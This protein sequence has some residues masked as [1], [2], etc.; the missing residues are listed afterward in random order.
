M[1]NCFHVLSICLA[2]ISILP[3]TTNAQIH[4]PY[5]LENQIRASKL[6]LN[7]FQLGKDDVSAKKGYAWEFLAYTG[8]YLGG[9]AVTTGLFFGG[10][11]AAWGSNGAVAAPLLIG[12]AVSALATPVLAA[13][14]MERVG[15]KYRPEG[16]LGTAVWASYLGMAVTAGG[17]L[18]LN[19]LAVNLRS[20]QE[21]FTDLSRAYYSLNTTA[22]LLVPGLIA[23]SVY[24]IFPKS[25]AAGIGNALLNRNGGEFTPG[26]PSLSFSP[27]PCLPGTH[28]KQF[29]LLNINF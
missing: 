8:G 23:V 15:R 5:D 13:Y 14:L 7:P 2:L 1:R 29:S 26:I 17:S 21:G 27:N 11:I 19:Y 10:F 28:F 4:T 6:N 25:E 18:L 9:A 22:M 16:K 3:V 24:N 20:N 12:S